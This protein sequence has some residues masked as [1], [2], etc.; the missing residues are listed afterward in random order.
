MTWMAIPLITSWAISLA[1]GPV[2]IPV[3]RRLKLGQAVRSQGPL[4][5]LSK[6]GTPTM[7]GVMFISAFVVATL[8]LS[9]RSPSTL[10]VLASGLGFGILG[11]IDDFLKVVMKSTLGLRARYKLLVQVG[12]AV[13]V[14]TFAQAQLGTEV[15]VPLLSTRWDL[16]VL[17]V[18]FAVVLMLGSAN[19][20]NLTDG[21]DGL[22]AGVSLIVAFAFV[23][24][25]SAQGNAGLAV[26]SLCLSGS[27]AGFLMYNIHP[28]KVFMGDTGALALGGT[29]GAL[30][31]MTKT[32]L[33]L[34]IIGA[35]FV[36]EAAS[37]IIQVVAFR[38][39]GKRVFRMAPLHHHFE[40]GGWS[41]RRVVKS[42]WLASLAFG[43]L[44]LILISLTRA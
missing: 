16:G 4:R 23:L 38:S 30:A 2:V 22:A 18:P 27:L 1:L 17:Y 33:F 42:F 43:V 13:F 14:G 41:E 36:A 6:S 26:L 19:G 44:G 31:I 40:L 9:D 35:V 28:A 37:D 7:G 20:V 25:A 24:I 5:H 3:L 11:L 39:T 21:L 8:A 29:I 34:P 10:V 32:E 15:I 12:I